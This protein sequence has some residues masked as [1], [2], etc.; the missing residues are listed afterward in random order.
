MLR[1]NES[2]GK[3]VVYSQGCRQAS[4]AS[5]LL[6]NTA[7]WAVMA[8]CSGVRNVERHSNPQGGSLRTSRDRKTKRYTI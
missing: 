4:V 6:N 3:Y 1:E 5:L 8:G 7:E 2:F